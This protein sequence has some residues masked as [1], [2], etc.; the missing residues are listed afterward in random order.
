MVLQ[1]SHL[2]FPRIAIVG[3]NFTGSGDLPTDDP[4]QSNI[5]IVN[6]QIEISPEAF[7]ED[8][9]SS[10]VLTLY[11]TPILFPVLPPEDTN[12]SL[13]DVIADTQVIGFIIPQVPNVTNVTVKITLQSLQG[14]NGTVSCVCYSRILV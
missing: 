7:P 4:P 6:S 5:T 14:R 8:V 10:Y 9:D 11:S 1:S 3:D 2:V 12:E 13:F